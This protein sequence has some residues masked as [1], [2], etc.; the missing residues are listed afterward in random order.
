MIE[1]VYV[2]PYPLPF[3]WCWARNEKCKHCFYEDQAEREGRVPVRLGFW[4]RRDKRPIVCTCVGGPSTCPYKKGW[5]E[6]AKEFEVLFVMR[7][8][9]LPDQD[10]PGIPE[11]SFSLGFSTFSPTFSPNLTGFLE[12]VK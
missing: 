10:I 7:Q 3:P 5:E 4:D 6:R 8:A 9:M 12:E 1:P 11:M 2:S